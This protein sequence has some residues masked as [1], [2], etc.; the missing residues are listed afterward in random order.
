[1][2]YLTLDE[3]LELHRLM[4]EQSGG[5]TGVRDQGLLESAIDQPAMTFSG[6]DLY[7]SLA[8]KAAALCFSLVMNHPFLDGNKRVGHAAM[9]VFLVLN[10]HELDASVEDQERAIMELAASQL[11]RDE[12]TAWVTAHVVVRTA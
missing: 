6:Q 1:M 10:G 12:L 9:D 7:P 4:L 3:V 2:R 11:T 8:S 5:I